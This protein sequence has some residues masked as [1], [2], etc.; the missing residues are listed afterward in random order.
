MGSIRTSARTSQRNPSE[1]GLSGSATA[2][3]GPWG[4]ANLEIRTCLSPELR[5]P[6]YP[7]GEGAEHQP[8]C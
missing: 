3:R 2:K 1:L 8:N 5:T 6:H 4:A 7:D